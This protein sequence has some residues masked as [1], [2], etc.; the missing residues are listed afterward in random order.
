MMSYII[1]DSDGNIVVIDGGQAFNIEYLIQTLQGITGKEKPVI[2]AWFLTHPH[3]DHIEAFLKA[4]EVDGKRVDIEKV[5]YNFPS[6]AFIEKYESAESYTISDFYKALPL[7]ENKTHIVRTEEQINIGRIKI[8]ILQTYTEVETNNAINNSSTVFRVT[9]NGKKII[10]LGDAGIEAG[11]RLLK[12][13]GEDLKSNVCQM[14][15][16]GQ[17]G[18]TKEVYAAISPEVCLWDTPEWLWNNDAGKGYNTHVFLTVEVRRWMEELGVKTN[19]C[20]KDGTNVL[21]F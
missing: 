13:Y 11:N 6:Q 14:A 15:H 10:F 21:Q 3:S 2:N 19:Y 17:R 9:L 5:Y 7:F 1:T 16:H 8:E 12:R 18:V 20:I 4:I